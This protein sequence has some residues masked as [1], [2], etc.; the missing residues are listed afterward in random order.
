MCIN[1]YIHYTSISIFYVHK[2]MLP[3]MREE[4][5]KISS[6]ECPTQLLN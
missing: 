1:A 3:P 2:H 5:W 6:A 4:R